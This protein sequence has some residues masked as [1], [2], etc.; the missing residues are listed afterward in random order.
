[1][2]H[3]HLR[4][5]TYILPLLDSILYISDFFFIVLFSFSVLVLIFYLVILSVAESK[6]L[7]SPTLFMDLSISPFISIIS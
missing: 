1:M 6:V 5:T 2:V 4:K 7:K 3:G